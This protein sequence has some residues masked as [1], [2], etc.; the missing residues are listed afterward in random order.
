MK[1]DSD[2]S[3]S[4]PR[5]AAVAIRLALLVSLPAWLGLA[6]RWHWLLDL[7]AH[8][9]AQYALALALGVGLALAT[10][11][12]R[13]ALYLGAISLLNAALWLGASGPM[14]PDRPTLPGSDWRLLLVNVHV[15]NP[16]LAPLLALIEREHP[17]LVAI[18]EL[19]PAA[20]AALAPL[21]ARYPVRLSEPR[22]DP[23]GI[24][25]WTRLPAAEVELLA[26]QPLQHPTLR[27][28]FA[29]PG[30]ANLWISHPFPPLGARAAH[31]RD[32]QLGELADWLSGDPGALLLGDLN[33][34]P[35]S[36]AYR[37]LRTRADLRD[38]RAGYFPWPTWYAGG[39]ASVMALPIDHVLVGHDWQVLD[40][41]V[42]PDIGSDHR[43]V[44]VRLA[45]VD[46]PAG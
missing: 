13:A 17:D 27:V 45:R 3:A 44:L 24:G 20:R 2:H 15:G 30:A 28:R 21:D 35:W 26:S 23:F 43:P 14:A 39:L 18:L 25:V 10:R 32:Q 19:S 6:G 40:Y 37:E 34:T 16:D 31:W 42:G 7:C 38:A 1:V 5:L 8:F 22:T 29:A 46:A 33:T 9:R 41:R 11:A 4:R 12:R 36:A